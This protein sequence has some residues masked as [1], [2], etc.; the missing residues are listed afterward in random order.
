MLKLI[1]LIL[2][3]LNPLKAEVFYSIDGIALDGYDPVAFYIEEKPLKGKERY[4]YTWNEVTWLFHDRINL[5][6][7]KHSPDKFLPEYGG[8]LCIHNFTRKY[9][10]C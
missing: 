7:F 9:C 10:K 4:N 3:L 2:V 8:F 5:E 6:L 1:F